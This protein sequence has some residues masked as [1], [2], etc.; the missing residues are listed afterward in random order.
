M[1]DP[2]LVLA[3]TS[4]I[5]AISGLIFGLLALTHNRYRAISEYL[6]KMHDDT[7]L[8][9]RKHVYQV[10][11]EGGIFSV[12]DKDAAEVINFYHI[13]GTMA[14]QRYL[15][16]W[17][18]KKR[19]SGPGALRLYKI[20]EPLIADFK[21]VHND[22][23]YANGYKWLAEKLE[24]MYRKDNYPLPETLPRAIPVQQAAMPKEVSK[25]ATPVGAN[26]SS[27]A[28]QQAQQ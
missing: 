15:P 21:H 11:R 26:S 27:T 9:A 5:T 1:L 22:P 4:V 7:F 10:H 25:E 18:F 13:W 24:K 2:Q 19:V 3:I 12:E 23:T 17:V 14:R 28:Q 16:M 8:S 20:L 6:C